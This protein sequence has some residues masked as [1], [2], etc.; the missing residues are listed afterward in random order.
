MPVRSG[1]TEGVS[2]PDIGWCAAQGCVVALD[3]LLAQCAVI[4]NPAVWWLDD[5][6]DIDEAIQRTRIQVHQKITQKRP[7][8]STRA[9]IRQIAI[10]EARMI[11]R[12]RFAATRPVHG[13]PADDELDDRQLDRISTT[14]A[15]GDLWRAA[16]AELPQAYAEAYL[17][18]EVS[19]LPYDEIAAQL[20]VPLSTA[21]TRVRRARLQL[22]EL[23]M[24]S[25][26]DR[27]KK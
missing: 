2:T 12:K 14:F 22:A 16:V 7:N 9:W 6:A 20:G 21:K 4:A 19:E 3:R 25:D 11:N 27:E 10:N 26:P 18:R 13:L 24:D 23:L 1:A 5:P 15:D 17:L 8:G